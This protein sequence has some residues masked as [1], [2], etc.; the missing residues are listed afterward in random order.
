MTLAVV[1]LAMTW[2]SALVYALF[3]VQ[4]VLL[5][6]TVG[7]FRWYTSALYPV[8]LVFFYVVFTLSALRRG[9]TVTWK[10][11]SIHAD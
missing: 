1:G 6:R 3:A 5:L 9:R 11:R 2:L 7:S 8:P 4:V 10:G